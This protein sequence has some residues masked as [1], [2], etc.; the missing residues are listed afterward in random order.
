[1]RTIQEETD[2]GW[3]DPDLV[4]LFMGMHKNVICKVADYTSTADHNLSALRNSISG[5]E[6]FL[7][8]APA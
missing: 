5:L 6:Q 3:R 8:I 4:K 2:R 1:M 7:S